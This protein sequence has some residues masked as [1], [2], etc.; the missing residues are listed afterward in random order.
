MTNFCDHRLR[1]IPQFVICYLSFRP[2][3]SRAKRLFTKTLKLRRPEL[4]NIE[5]KTGNWRRDTK[6]TTNENRIAP[7]GA[8]T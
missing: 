6:G 5:A 3:V 1:A 7:F 4:L 8:R 2:A